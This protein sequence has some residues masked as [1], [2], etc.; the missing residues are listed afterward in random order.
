MENTIVEL[1]EAEQ[2][3]PV[4][5]VPMRPRVNID[6]FP[7]LL[8]L[9]V[10]HRPSALSDPMGRDFDYAREFKSLDLRP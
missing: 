6:W 7:D 5:H 3:C 1:T 2:G 9:S 4:R 10:L 8:D